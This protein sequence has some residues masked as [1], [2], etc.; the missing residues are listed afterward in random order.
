MDIDND[1]KLI[2]HVDMDAFFVSVE[3]VLNPGLRGKP[4]IVGGDPEGRG[5][6]SAA[7]YKAREYGVRS[8]MPMA[9]AKRLCPRAV[10]LR[11][12]MR[13]YAEFS[14][15][16]MTILERYT[17]AVEK[18]SVDEAYLDVTG[19]ERF[20]KARRKRQFGNLSE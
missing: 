16:I 15:R 7:S 13:T 6:V 4:V 8:A 18:M 9:E 5:V 11:G 14:S 12:S 10:F 19:C 20:H 3:M 17:P 1:K 2:L